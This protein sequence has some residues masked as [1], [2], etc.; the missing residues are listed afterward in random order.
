MTGPTPGP[1]ETGALYVASD[2]STMWFSAQP[3]AVMAA[4]VPVAPGAV[5]QVDVAEP[6]R[7]VAWTAGARAGSHLVPSADPLPPVGLHE[8]PAPAR[9]PAHWAR[10][11]LVHGVRRW[12]PQPVAEDTLIVD[13]ALA[14]ADAGLHDE[15]L[16]R[17]DLASATLI[18]LAEECLAGELPAVMRPQLTAAAST[19]AELLSG[20]PDGDELAELADDLSIPGV[21]TP[22]PELPVLFGGRRE[23]DGLSVDS[24]RVDPKLAPA[25]ILRWNGAEVPE[26]L[27]GGVDG[28]TV[29]YVTLAADVLAT[30]REVVDLRLSVVDRRTGLVLATYRMGR[31]G[32]R[33]GELTV[34][35]PDSH[36]G[37]E[38]S[39]HI[40]SA[41]VVPDFRYSTVGGHLVTADRWL[42]DAWSLSRLRTAGGWA[43]SDEERH[44]WY[45]AQDAFEDLAGLPQVIGFGDAPWLAGVR[46]AAG[47]PT[48][49]DAHGRLRA[50][51]D[52]RE[53]M[54]VRS[55]APELGP[56]LAEY[57]FVATADNPD[58]PF[59]DPAGSTFE[60]E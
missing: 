55:G 17:F 43:A 22:P 14:A 33:P 18:R 45:Q 27:V 5:V 48:A 10:L 4:K 26:V 1:S 7:V 52:M 56:L 40:H 54:A 30:D 29:V 49:D 39:L 36:P 42:V 37:V 51:S 25:R 47:T 24:Y 15:A 2:G 31:S 23:G 60:D 20:T 57:E 19:A 11:G 8:F 6:D 13:L 41:G 58:G 9:L 12:L 21:A 28:S 34:A 38:T 53:A 35:L 3:A 59:T 32:D 50:V 16:A 44:G 46:W